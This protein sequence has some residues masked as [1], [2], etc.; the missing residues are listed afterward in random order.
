MQVEALRTRMTIRIEGV[1]DVPAARRVCELLSAAPEGEHVSLDLSKV[2][3]FQDPGVAVLAEALAG[4]GSS[5]VAV[6]GLRHH[7]LRMLRYLGVPPASIGVPDAIPV[8]RV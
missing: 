5:R 4:P 1:F 2:R 7:Q 6:C 3:E 8:E